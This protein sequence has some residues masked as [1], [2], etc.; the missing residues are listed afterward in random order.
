LC[1]PDK[2]ITNSKFSAEEELMKPEHR[3]SIVKRSLVSWILKGNPKFKLLLLVAAIVTVLVR[4]IPLEMQKRIVNQA[5]SMKA[6][7]LLLIYCGIYLAAVVSASALKYAISYLQ[8]IIGQRALTDM[9]RELYRHVLSLPLSFF[10]KTQPGMVVQSFASELATAGDFIG[11]AVAIP[12]V[13]ILSLTAFTIYLLWLNP[14]LALVSFAIYPLA[15]FVLPALQ[16]RANQEN[17]K[18]VDISREY[19][20]KIAEAVSGIHEIQ[21]NAAFRLECGKFDSLAEKLMK[22]RITWNLYRQGM[23]VGSNFFSSISPFVI[24]LLGG[25]LSINGELELGSLVAFLSAQEKLFDPWR[26]LIDVYQSYQ[27]A[28]VSYRQTMQYFDHEPEFKLEPQDRKPYQL[29]GEIDVQN[30]SYRTDDDVQLLNGINFSVNPGE[31]MALVGFSGSGKSTLAQC[32]GQLYK[33]TSGH[34]LIGNREVADL[35]KKDIAYNVGLV[36]QSPYIFDG[37]IEDNL[38]YGCKARLNGDP[39]GSGPT[40]PNLDEKIE[41]IQQTGIFP[42]ILRFGLNSV[43]DRT[44]YP[45]LIKPLIRLRKKL[46]SRLSPALLEHVEFFDK[47]KYLYHSSLAQNLT[48]GFANDNS[49]NRESLSKNEY[50]RRFLDENGLTAP[51]LKLGLALCEKTIDILGNL[52]PDQSFFEQCPIKSEELDDYKTLQGQL[53]KKTAADQMTPGEKEKFIELALRFIPGKHK[54]ITLPAELQRQILAARLKFRQQISSDRPGAYLFYRKKEYIHSHTI[55]NNIFFGRLKTASAQIQDRI[56][57]QIVQLLIEENLM[58]SVVEIGMQ[59][60]VGSKGDR[61][62]G[63]QRQKLAIARAFLKKPKILIMDEATSAL[64]NNSQARIQRHLDTRLKGSTTLI[65]VVHRL[66]IIKSYDKIGVLKSGKIEEIGTY[67]ELM[68]KRG[69]LYGLVRGR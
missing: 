6:F 43:L 14:M 47:N 28:G 10:R 42:D 11:M 17:K 60:Q 13:S 65:A 45:Q 57:E 58:E 40:L 8:T 15:I 12:L 62:S 24:F 56:N 59:F 63:G 22:I 1:F 48:F 9:R 46:A 16:R 53:K 35:T 21:G 41:I 20:G 29:D 34:L 3:T 44:S 27:E 55:L 30:L 18:R 50:F 2:Q 68:E 54:M 61:L 36:S 52:P 66:D 26:E 67:D 7:D 38:L 25:W 4:V 32:I 5:I 33:Y 31:Q 49:F 37:T 23:K 39:S 69:L 19:S 64:D 51:L